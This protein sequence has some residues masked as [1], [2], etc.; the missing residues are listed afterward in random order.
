MYHVFLLLY[1]K[2]LI[3]TENMEYVKAY[4]RKATHVDDVGFMYKIYRHLMFAVFYI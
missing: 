1:I 3:H 2:V 4:R